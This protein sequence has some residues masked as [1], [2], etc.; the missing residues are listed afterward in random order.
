MN[1]K[2]TTAKHPKKPSSSKNG[3]WISQAEFS[4]LNANLLEAQ[5]TLEAIRSGEVDAVVVHGPNGNQ[6]YSLTGAEQPYRVYVEQMQEGAVTVSADGLILYCN[7]RFADMMQAPLERVI[8][9]Q[10]SAYLAAEA[11]NTI[12]AV[13]D[14]GNVVKYEGVL[15]RASHGNL[16]VNLTAS[17]L[18][19]ENQNVMCLVVTDLTEQKKHEEVRMARE[20]AEKASLAK[21][22]FLAA[23]SHELRT[24]LTPVLITANALEQNPSLTAEARESLKLIRRNVELEVRLID[25]LLDLTRIAHGKMELQLK[26]MDFHALIHRA[27]E[28]CRP[29]FN[30]RSQKIVLD[31]NAREHQGASDAVRVQQAIWNLIRNAA[32]FTPESGLIDIRTSNP[33]PGKIL[34]E[35]QDTGIGFEPGVGEKLFD[36]F[37]QGGR[38]ITRRFGGLGLGLAIT[39]SIIE[40][41]D[42]TIRAASAGIG[43]GATFTFEMPLMSAKFIPNENSAPS[44]DAGQSAAG[45]HILLVEDH[46]DTR[47]TLENLLRKHKYEVKAAGSARE[48]LELAAEN[49][50]D[51]VISDF[52]LPDQSGLEL[53]TQLRDRFGLK[54]IGL[55]GYGMD[56]DIAKG[57]VA[58]F[59]RHLTK[60]IRFDRLTEVIA[61]VSA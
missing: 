57:R 40:A 7:Q 41:H 29:E 59:V 27:L 47:T 36:A 50:F 34:I 52:G 14:R 39:R 49:T 24:P 16:P 21:D 17:R 58:G 13:F 10:M 44:S 8:S 33:S 61:E 11:W 2:A 1:K 46:E 53:M 32:K 19:L 48:A 4:R 43:K 54:G 45:K 6:I 22:D 30:A 51:L 56:T 60:P 42:G 28:I 38:H 55:S 31:L 20:L 12:C 23:L 37:V 5:E 15:S 25:D 18:P 35:I 3:H 9:S 26:R